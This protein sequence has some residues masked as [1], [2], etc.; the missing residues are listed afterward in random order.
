MPNRLTEHGNIDIIISYNG[1]KRRGA[2]TMISELKEELQK[3]EKKL[4]AL[5]GYL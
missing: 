2:V 4:K 3:V 1:P 5:R